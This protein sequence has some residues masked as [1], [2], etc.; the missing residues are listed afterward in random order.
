MDDAIDGEPLACRIDLLLPRL[1][2]CVG[3][4]LGGLPK[5]TIRDWKLLARSVRK[6]YVSLVSAL[7]RVEKERLDAAHFAEL[8]RVLRPMAESPVRGTVA[9]LA[10][11][12][13]AAFEPIWREVVLYAARA[14]RNRAEVDR[15]KDSTDILCARCRKPA[16]RFARSA[17]YPQV[18]LTPDEYGFLKFHVEAGAPRTLAIYLQKHLPYGLPEY[19]PPCDAFYCRDCAPQERHRFLHNDH[20]AVM[21]RCPHGHERQVDKD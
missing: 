13:L 16:L 21:I 7:G 20:E 9:S 4:L 18:R 19:C 15:E 11:K 12:A 1:D 17:T 5:G 14:S 8:W 10:R 6:G 3:R 2:L